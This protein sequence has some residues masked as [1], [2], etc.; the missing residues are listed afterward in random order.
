MDFSLDLGSVGMNWGGRL[1]R[2]PS[3]WYPT[4]TLV[5]TGMLAGGLKWVFSLAKIDSFM[6]PVFRCNSCADSHTWVKRWDFTVL[7]GDTNPF[8]FSITALQ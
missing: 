1:M 6:F 4:H 3:M 2:S 8:F 5:V 7:P